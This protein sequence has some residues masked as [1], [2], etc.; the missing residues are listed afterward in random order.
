MIGPLSTEQTRAVNFGIGDQTITW[1]EVA[2]PAGP[3]PI[4]T[5]CKGIHVDWMEGF[6]NSPSV[7]LK[8][9]QNLG[10]WPNKKFRKEGDYYR[11]Y[12]DDGQMVQYAHS[13]A[14]GK[15]LLAAFRRE[16]GTI[17]QNRRSG[18][19]WASGVP[20]DDYAAEPGEWVKVEMLATTPSQGFGGAN[21]WCPM[22]DGTTIVLRGPWHS[23]PK[24]GYADVAY[25]NVKDRFFRPYRK[26]MK[27]HEVT[28]IGGLYLSQESLV[29][30]LSK[31]AAHL[32]I[33]AVTYS[34]CTT[35]EPYLAEWGVPKIVKY[36][37]DRREKYG[38]A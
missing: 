24:Q 25:V 23:G 12:S 38:K 21:F 4:P 19:E 10:D 33:A 36:Y 9:N 16:D 29:R 17:T 13:G 28:Q 3:Q 34:G 2:R 15:V 22:E 7:V 26:G 14:V 32:P 1:Q 31:F 8:T 6:S 5:W 20:G 30:I 11:A 37:Q 18:C 27:W 35:I